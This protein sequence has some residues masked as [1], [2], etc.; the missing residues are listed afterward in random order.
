MEGVRFL[1]HPPEAIM[2]AA[3]SCWR[4][5]D[6]EV[7]AWERSLLHNTMRLLSGLISAREPDN[8]VLSQATLAGHGL[9]LSRPPRRA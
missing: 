4:P 1:E 9:G 8:E 5:E 6:G 2:L 3:A 7:R